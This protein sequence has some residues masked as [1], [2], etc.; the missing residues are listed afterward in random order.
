MKYLSVLCVLASAS[1][2]LSGCTKNFVQAYTKLDLNDKSITVPAGGKLNGALKKALKDDGWRLKVDSNTIVTEGSN[3]KETYKEKTRVESDTRYRLLSTYSGD[4][5]FT[6]GCVSSYNISIIDNKTGE[7]IATF[8]G[9]ER[10][11]CYEDV[12]KRVLSWIHS[13]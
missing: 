9:R 5:C 12:A 2:I 10:K 3:S 8:D 11:Q 7:E 4:F 1:I 6:C 13:Q